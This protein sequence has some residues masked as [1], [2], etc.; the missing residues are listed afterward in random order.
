MFFFSCKNLLLFQKFEKAAEMFRK[1]K[2]P[3]KSCKYYELAGRYDKSIDVLLENKE[4]EEAI[5]SLH[6]YQVRI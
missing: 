1:T 6:R 4:F 3:L 2:E 5:H